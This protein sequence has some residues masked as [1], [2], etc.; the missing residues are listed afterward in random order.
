MIEVGEGPGYDVE[1]KRRREK[2]TDYGKRLEM[3]KSGDLRAVVRLS[4][5]HA[6]VQM[7]GYVDGGDET[8]VEAFSKQLREFG[9]DEHPGNLPAAYLTG[10]LAGYRAQDEG[11]ERC[12][13]DIGVYD[14]EEGSR[15]YAAVKG[16][17]DSGLG[18]PVDGEVLP[19]ESRVRGEHIDDETAETFEK[20]REEI[21]DRYGD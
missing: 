9:W 2:K 3:L 1:L 8:V 12:I 18:V 6:R 10:L 7:V 5:N 14:R 13:A 17:R 15:H 20:V 21:S 16:L 4:N 11:I 19:E